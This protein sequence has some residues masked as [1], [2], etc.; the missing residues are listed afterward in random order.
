MSGVSVADGELRHPGGPHL[1]RAKALLTSKS[2]NKRAQQDETPRQKK[3]RPSTPRRR[4]PMQSPGAPSMRTIVQTAPAANARMLKQGTLANRR[5]HQQQASQLPIHTPRTLTARSVQQ[6][7]GKAAAAASMTSAPRPRRTSMTSA[8]PAR[9]ASMTSAPPARRASVT[10]VAPTR[11]ASV[12]GAAP[13]RRASLSAPK[14]KA[15][16]ATAKPALRSTPRPVVHDADDE[17]VLISSTDRDSGSSSPSSSPGSHTP[18]HSDSLNTS[19]SY[20]PSSNMP[21]DGEAEEHTESY[22]H[23]HLPDDFDEELAELAKESTSSPSQ[24][25]AVGRPRYEWGNQAAQHKAFVLWINQQLRFEGVTID[26]LE[27]TLTDG[28]VLAQL[29]SVLFGKPVK[30]KA[31]PKFRLQKV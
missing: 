30:Y 16:P 31:E 6:K 11:R 17:P 1:A 2:T 29:V 19:V 24:R 23:V 18:A 10:R 26:S 12:T 5:V 25:S 8:P 9:R 20:S 14:P 13:A 3:P 27:H 21:C 22:L 15:R 4:S 7:K 28:T